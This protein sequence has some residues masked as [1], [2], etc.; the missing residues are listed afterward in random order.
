MSYKGVELRMWGLAKYVRVFLAFRWRLHSG[1][2]LV[3]LWAKKDVMINYSVKKT[4]T[5]N[6]FKGIQF[7]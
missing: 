6:M 2:I 7:W 4:M 3:Y 5:C 1:D